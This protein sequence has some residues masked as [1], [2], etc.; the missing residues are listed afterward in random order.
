MIPYAN[1]IIEAS[2]QIEAKAR[3][4]AREEINPLLSR[5]GITLH[6][7]TETIQRLSVVKNGTEEAKDLWG[8]L[9][10]AGDILD[11]EFIMLKNSTPIS[12]QNEVEFIKQCL[13][14]FTKMVVDGYGKR[15]ALFI[16]TPKFQVLA[17]LW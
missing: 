14:F 5:I 16:I 7:I 13:V 10:R 1:E 4:K 15:E 11:E 6:E 17:R 2:G 9:Y 3:K 12:I 8:I